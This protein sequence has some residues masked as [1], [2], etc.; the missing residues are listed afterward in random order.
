[1]KCPECGREISNKENFC[2]YC[3][4][5][6]KGFDFNDYAVQTKKCKVC[7]ASI[8]QGAVFCIQCGNPI[9]EN[10]LIISSNK[11]ELKEVKKS[12]DTKWEKIII[13]FLTIITLSLASFVV[14]C[15]VDKDSLGISDKNRTETLETIHVRKEIKDTEMATEAVQNPS[16]EM[17][18]TSE[19]NPVHHRIARHDGLIIEIQPDGNITY[20]NLEDG[21]ILPCPIEYKNPISVYNGYMSRA[22]Y[23]LQS[24][25]KVVA[26][27]DQ[28]T[29]YNQRNEHLVASLQNVAELAFIEQAAYSSV[30]LENAIAIYKDGTVDYVDDHYSEVYEETMRMAEELRTWTDIEHIFYRT[31]DEILGIRSDG[32]VVSCFNYNDF[33]VY[34]SGKEAREN[35]L[36]ARYRL[37]DELN[38]WKNIKK[39]GIGDEGYIGLQY[40]GKFVIAYLDDLREDE[41]YREKT[42]IDREKYKEKLGNLTDITNIVSGEWGELYALKGDGSVIII[43]E[44][45]IPVKTFW[46]DIEAIE[47]MDTSLAGLK[48]DGTWMFLE[49]RFDLDE[50]SEDN[51]D[52]ME[53]DDFNEKSDIITENE[54]ISKYQEYAEEIKGRDLEQE[55]VFANSMDTIIPEEIIKKATDE[56]LRIGKNEIYALHGRRFKDQNLQE[57]FDN[58]SWYQGTIAPEKFKEEVFSTVEKE[59]IKRIQ[60]E[61][62]RR[63]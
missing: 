6:I 23:I 25:G 26:D 57:Y 1:M 10:S 40:D 45:D 61:I 53:E 4:V 35:Y 12:T 59:N 18:I 50:Q 55:F 32:A 7:G 33:P 42:R 2:K 21:T 17:A 49:S 63:K 36:K 9:E 28:D 48:N 30:G 38:S 54:T 15:V 16:K 58:C 24:N 62:E 29:V 39:L 13:A 41:K 37:Q 11:R 20:T 60:A 27:Y 31:H 51:I 8:K 47:K 3:G 34:I 56:E 52:T 22:V 19:R 5:R 46:T 44:G 14:Y 43:E